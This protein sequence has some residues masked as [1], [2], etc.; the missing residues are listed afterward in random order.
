MICYSSRIKADKH[1]HKYNLFTGNF[2]F[3]HLSDFLWCLSICHLSMN[4]F[5][6]SAAQSHCWTDQRVPKVLM[7]TWISPDL[8]HR[9]SGATGFTCDV[10][11]I[12]WLQS[13]YLYKT[14]GCSDG[15][16][17]SGSR[18]HQLVLCF[19]F[20]GNIWVECLRFHAFVQFLYILF[21]S[22]SVT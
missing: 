21:P 6:S 10:L 14:E 16:V 15:C 17:F 4:L 8:D 22:R 9:W 19:L 13:V 20:G 2:I 12:S 11:S 1:T 5:Y 7:W 18:H 3:H